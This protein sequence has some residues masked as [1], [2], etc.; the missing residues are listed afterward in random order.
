MLS[1]PSYTRVGY[2]GRDVGIT[3]Y[4]KMVA[5]ILAKSPTVLP[6]GIL[7]GFPYCSRPD[8]LKALMGV[9]GG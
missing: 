4:T 5:S 1:S 6:L 3:F 7:I 8:F 9:N 2:V